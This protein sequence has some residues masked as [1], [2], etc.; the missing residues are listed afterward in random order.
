MKERRE[1]RLS[2]R[3]ILF[4]LFL[5]QVG[6]ATAMQT[7]TPQGRVGYTIDCSG[8]LLNWGRCYKKAGDLCAERGYDVIDKSSEQGQTFAANQYAASGGSVISR[9]MLITCK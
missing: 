3:E 6:C 5:S 1:N 4:A 2:L 8:S 9:S 7:Y